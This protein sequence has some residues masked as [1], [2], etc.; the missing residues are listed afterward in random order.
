MRNSGECWQDKDC[1]DS[2][3]C[4]DNKCNAGKCT[5][6]N[7]TKLCVSDGD[8]CTLNDQCLQGKCQGTAVACQD[9]NNVCTTQACDSKTGKCVTTGIPWCNG[10]C[11]YS[12]KPGCGGCKCEAAVCKAMPSCCKENWSSLCVQLCN[13]KHGG[14]DK[15]PQ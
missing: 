14:C 13:Q 3:V 2:N 5:S 7:N 9:D 11:Y 15:V 8:A 6:T 1:N 10:G 4:T 12:D